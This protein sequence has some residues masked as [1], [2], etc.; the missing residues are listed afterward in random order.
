MNPLDNYIIIRRFLEELVKRFKWIIK[1]WGNFHI[2]VV[3]LTVRETGDK[4]PF[5]PSIISDSIG[6]KNFVINVADITIS[7]SSLS[8]SMN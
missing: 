8:S 1:I 7:S 4:E 3:C 6:L 2:Q 5:H